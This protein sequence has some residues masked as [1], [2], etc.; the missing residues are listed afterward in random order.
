MTETTRIRDL[1]D[2]VVGGDA[3]HG[4]SLLPLLAR[5]PPELAARRVVPGAHTIWELLL[6]ATAWQEI[7][8][9][10][11]AG[12]PL[13]EVS[14]SEDWPSPGPISAGG[15]K[16]AVAA[17]ADGHR[18]LAADLEALPDG[19]LDDPAPGGGTIYAVLSGLIQHHTYH[20]GQIALLERAAGISAV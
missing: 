12:E 19:R 7:V 1:L 16:T 13:V 14:A 4:P 15:W 6:H 9:R 11:L 5:V 18:R 10:R 3:W 20:A 2:R 17:L 8:R